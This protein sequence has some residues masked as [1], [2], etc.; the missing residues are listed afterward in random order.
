MIY[1]V[2]A[3]IAMF[4]SGVFIWDRSRTE[5]S[6]GNLWAFLILFGIIYLAMLAGYWITK[7]LI[8]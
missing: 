6:K 5:H 2:L 8:T 4:I 3:I 7:W 1:N